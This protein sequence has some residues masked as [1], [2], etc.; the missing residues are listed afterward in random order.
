MLAEHNHHENLFQLLRT[1][2][3]AGTNCYK[4]QGVKAKEP[5]LCSSDSIGEKFLYP[6]FKSFPPMASD[7]VDRQ[8]DFENK[9][10]RMRRLL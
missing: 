7:E 3:C 2:N 10:R 9:E 1:S 6:S 5:L 8:L 4:C